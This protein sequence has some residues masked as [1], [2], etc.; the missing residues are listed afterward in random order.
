MNDRDAILAVAR[1]AELDG[2][3]E[4]AATIR[5]QI[6]DLSPLEQLL[7]R[8][9]RSVTRRR[10]VTRNQ[11]ETID[12]VC[13]DGTRWEMYCEPNDV[14]NYVTWEIEEVIGDLED[15]VGAPIAIADERCTFY[16]FATVKGCVTVRWSGSSNGV[17]RECASSVVSRY[18]TSNGLYSERTT[19]CRVAP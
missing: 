18:G 12:F 3:A 15:L 19:F 2:R 8:T 16:R 13:I 11:T 6:K 9:M 10:S 1:D 5:S 14:P 7:G 4:E 17:Y